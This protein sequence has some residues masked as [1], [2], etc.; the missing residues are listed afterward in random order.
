M[1]VSTWVRRGKGGEKERRRAESCR[2]EVGVVTVRGHKG[3]LKSA[4]KRLRE[5]TATESASLS[6]VKKVM[7]LTE[8]SSLFLFG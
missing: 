4:T 7:I 5:T 3:E 6:Q 8:F 2:T 1:W